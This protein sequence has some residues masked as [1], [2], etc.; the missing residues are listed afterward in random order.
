[1]GGSAIARLL[2][3]HLA[4]PDW[5]SAVDDGVYSL[6]QMPRFATGAGGGWCFRGW[7]GPGT[8]RL[9]HSAD[10]PQHWPP[11]ERRP[12]TPGGAV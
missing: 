3:L 9:Y 4:R 12:A 2:G 8:G 7:L 6:A 1:V 11:G 10:R 5:P